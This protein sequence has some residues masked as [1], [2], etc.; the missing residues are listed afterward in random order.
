V[1]LTPRHAP[2]PTLAAHRTFALQWEGVDLLVLKRLFLAAGPDEITAFVR[3][4]PTG[5]YARRTWF[6][7][8]WL[9]GEELEIANPTRGSFV[10]IL[11]PERQ[12]AIPG[13]RSSRHHVRNNLP[14]TPDFCPLVF[15]TEVLDGFTHEDLAALARDAIAPIPAEIVARAAAF[16]LREDSKS[17]FA[18]EGERPPRRRIER[19]GRAICQAGRTSLDLE[20]LLRLQRTLTGDSRFVRL[21]LRED[22]GFVGEHERHTGEP[23]P[24]HLSARPEDL[25]ALIGGLVTFVSDTSKASDPVVAAACSSFGF[26]YIHSF[27]D[28]NGRLHRYLIHH[29]L[30][31]RGFNP[32]GLAFP[33]S[34][35]ILRL[36]EDYRHVLEGFPSQSSPTDSSDE[37]Q[38]QGTC[39]FKI[40]HGCAPRTVE[41]RSAEAVQD[42]LGCRSPPGSFA[43]GVGHRS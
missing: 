10:D 23:I 40:A 15:R 16:L 2:E 38:Y 20:E 21:G 1:L 39:K 22:G 26:V 28:G 25:T 5:S 6:L 4:Q 31:E 33:V 8:E 18:I 37:A 11:D 29:V 36:I 24:R 12:F 34:A 7:Y 43:G 41:P 35:V 9:T 17:S 19:W 27:E 3:S 32:H 42:V 13:A 14:G 30:A